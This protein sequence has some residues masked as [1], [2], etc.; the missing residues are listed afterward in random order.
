MGLGGLNMREVQ[1][2]SKCLR[3]GG[4]DLEFKNEPAICAVRLDQLAARPYVRI[5]LHCGELGCKYQ[6]LR[7]PEE[8]MAGLVKRHKSPNANAFDLADGMTGPCPFC[9][10]VNWKVEVLW[11][12]TNSMNWNRLG[13]GVFTKAGRD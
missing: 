13:E 7:R 11:A 3:V 9:K 6:Q 4:C 12:D 5:R 1:R 2:L 10:K 8:V